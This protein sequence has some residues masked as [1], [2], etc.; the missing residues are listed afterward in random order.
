MK[1]KIIILLIFILP[2]AV[3]AILENLNKNSIANENLTETFDKGQLI[4][5]YSPMC[6]ECKTVAKQIDEVIKDYLDKII[7]EEID[8]SEK[9]DKTNN[10]IE[11]YEIS[12]V[13]TVI[14][15]KKNGKIV[16]KTTGVM[17]KSEIR[18]YLD[19]ISND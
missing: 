7:Y 18:K 19:E 13:P 1:N 3:F 17:S 16:N 5:F 11:K 2:I 12:V 6:S 4:K 14:F 9:N 15:T 10:L 8:V